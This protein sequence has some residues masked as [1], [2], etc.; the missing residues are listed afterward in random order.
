[1]TA[2][3]LNHKQQELADT[4]LREA[5]QRFPEIALLSMQISP[6]DA[7]HIWLNVNAPDDE[8]R[9]MELRS[10]TA[11]LCTDILLDYGYAFSVMPEN[12]TLAVA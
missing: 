11:E 2:P 1:M 6:D 12:P 8:E 10:Y 9:E 3:R 4:I 5:Q 7:N